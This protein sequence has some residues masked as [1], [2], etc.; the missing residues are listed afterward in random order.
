MIILSMNGSK[1]VANHV[2][3]QITNQIADALQKITISTPSSVALTASTC[4]EV[5]KYTENCA[6]KCQVLLLLGRSLEK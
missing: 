4:A 5:T 3:L 2:Y 6:R 1:V